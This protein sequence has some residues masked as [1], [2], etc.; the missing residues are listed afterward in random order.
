MTAFLIRWHGPD[1][2]TIYADGVPV[3]S[4]SDDN[5]FPDETP[6]SRAAYLRT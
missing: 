3:G 1:A 4:A 6:S 2:V 5:D